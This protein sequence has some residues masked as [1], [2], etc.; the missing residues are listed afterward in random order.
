M[1][2]AHTITRD[3]RIVP[4]NGFKK[5]TPTA[6]MHRYGLWQHSIERHS[7]PD[8]PVKAIIVAVMVLAVFTAIVLCAPY[9]IKP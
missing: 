7:A 2:T 6:S 3:G 9:F 4:G 5:P 8:E 1:K